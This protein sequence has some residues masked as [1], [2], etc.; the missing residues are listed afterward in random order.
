MIQSSI[1]PSLPLP[2]IIL[3][4]VATGAL[5]MILL[6]LFIMN[7]KLT[8]LSAKLTRY[9]RS[10][11]SEEQDASPNAVEAPSGTHFE[12]FLNEDSNRRRLTKKEQ[13]KAYRAWRSK[14]GLNWTK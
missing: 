5:V 2:I 9:S 12:E 14:K 8:A 11:K 4:F 10:A 13:F 7:S 1:E 3:C 6:L